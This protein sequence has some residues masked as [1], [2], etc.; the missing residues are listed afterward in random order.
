VVITQVTNN[1][2]DYKYTQ[3][4]NITSNV[5]VTADWAE[6]DKVCAWSRAVQTALMRQ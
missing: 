5:K 4:R 1:T 3:G 6:S 2:T